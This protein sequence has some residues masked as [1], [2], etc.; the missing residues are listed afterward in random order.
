[1]P[2]LSEAERNQAIEMLLGGV[3]V[4]DESR[5]FNCSRNTVH[6]LVRRYR[7]TGD[8]HDRPRPGRSRATTKRDDRAIVLTHLRDRFRPVIL[9]A[10]TFNVTAQTIHNRLR[11]QQ[12]PIRARHP[13]T[14]K[15]AVFSLYAIVRPVLGG[16]V[17]TVTGGD[18]TGILSCLQASLVT[19][20]LMPTN[21]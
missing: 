6:E 21:V 17:R 12:C 4:V 14:H 5:T 7:L 15:H 16:H 2:R 20:S 18:V 19:I 13:Y 10:P 8:V 3:S 11:A 1:M 9:T